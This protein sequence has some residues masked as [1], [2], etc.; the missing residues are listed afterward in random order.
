MKFHTIPLSICIRLTKSTMMALTEVFSQVL[1]SEDLDRVDDKSYEILNSVLPIDVHD[2]D[3]FMIYTGIPSPSIRAQINKLNYYLKQFEH[4]TNHSK[5]S[6]WIQKEKNQDLPMFQELKKLHQKW[7]PEWD[8]K[9]KTIYLSIE[10]STEIDNVYNKNENDNIIGNNIKKK[11]NKKI[12]FKKY[13]SR[14]IRGQ[15]K[16]KQN[17]RFSETINITNLRKIRYMPVLKLIN[18]MNKNRKE[19]N[20]LKE[21]IMNYELTLDN[22]GYKKVHYKY[23]KKDKHKK[24]RRITKET[25]S[26]QNMHK[27]IRGA[28]ASDYYYDFD[29]VNCHPTILQ[30]ICK[31]NKIECIELDYYIKY[32]PECIK[33]IQRYDKNITKEE[34]KNIY[35]SCINGGNSALEKLL[36]TS[37][38]LH[39]IRFKNEINTIRNKL[40]KIYPK[41][42]KEIKQRKEKKQHNKEKKKKKKK[43]KPINAFLAVICN[44]IENF[45]L[46]IMIDYIKDNFFRNSARINAVLCS[47]GIMI[48]KHLFKNKKN[49]E[50]HILRIKNRIHKILGIEIDLINKEMKKNIYN[51][52]S[53]K[54]TNTNKNNKENKNNNKKNNNINK[55]PK[56]FIFHLPNTEENREGFFRMYDEIPDSE[57]IYN[58]NRFITNCN[59]NTNNCKHYKKLRNENEERNIKEKI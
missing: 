1:P 13:V 6:E 34:I 16:F 19:I 2:R 14:I 56:E 36:F 7:I 43:K 31:I 46:Q 47:D 24:E 41:M 18:I 55:I 48:P 57:K 44:R 4:S 39:I 59:C 21:S 23:S 29:L 42:M 8:P 5:I 20:K 12:Y 22:N 53:N 11:T 3:Q 17:T 25:L 40:I 28:I 15:E 10:E 9:T 50:K 35:I 30:Y 37:N 58:K 38:K 27:M 49:M 45:I 32:R 26:L 51:I 33:E 52:I 54:N